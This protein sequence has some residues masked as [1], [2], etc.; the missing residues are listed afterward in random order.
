VFYSSL[1]LNQNHPPIFYINKMQEHPAPVKAT[2]LISNIFSINNAILHKSSTNDLNHWTQM[3]RAP[4]VG[5]S[6]F[7]SFAAV[8]LMQAKGLFDP[9]TMTVLLPSIVIWAL[10][11]LVSLNCMLI[12]E[13]VSLWSPERWWK[14]DH[15]KCGWTPSS[16]KLVSNSIL[17]RYYPSLLI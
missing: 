4:P 3:F 1:L 2:K 10:F 12:G 15:E 6:V 9:N 16:F 13:L 5:F 11:W 7:F 8:V 17:T 14:Y